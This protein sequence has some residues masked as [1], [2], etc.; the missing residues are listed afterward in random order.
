MESIFKKNETNLSLRSKLNLYKKRAH[1][2][3]DYLTKSPEQWEKFQAE[4]NSG[5]NTIFK[6]IM[7]F[8]KTCYSNG[9][10]EK[11]YKLKRIFIN[12]IREFFL[13]GAYNEWS[14]RKPYGYA[15][16]FKIIDDIYQNNPMTTGFVRLFDNY[17]LMSAISIAVRNR[18]DDFKKLIGDF[19]KEKKRQNLRIMSLASGSCRDV[20]E[21]LLSD[22][23]LCD[24]LF[25][26][27]YDNDENALKY[28]KILLRG[29][30][31]FN[32]IK[33][34]A[35]KIALRKDISLMIDKK[36][37]LIYATGLFDYFNERVG[38]PLVRNLK[39]LLK[40]GGVLAIST[41][42]N[43]YSNPSV[44][45]M[46]WVGDWNLVYRNEEE[47]KTIFLEA[48][49]NED[50]LRIQYEQQGIMQYIITK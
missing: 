43:K 46:E 22:H 40:P 10:E 26:D 18:K 37:D 32:F 38:I 41:M 39:K 49:F 36:Y 13:K 48:G 3:E 5:V 31:I 42:R 23:K 14:L 9:Q 4:F 47:F 8:E 27:C 7:D 11:V 1:E 2:I 19:V 34:N 20:Y 25:F 28:A 45:Y 17:F 30:S 44:H 35:V 12:K 21:F 16:D 6:D 33:E 24:N 29:Y 50:E 15:G